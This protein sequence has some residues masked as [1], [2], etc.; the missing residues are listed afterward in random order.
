M[1]SRK[2]SRPRPRRRRCSRA[3]RAPTAIAQASAATEPRADQSAE[4]AAASR[5]LPPPAPPACNADTS[6]ATASDR[7]LDQ[8][9]RST[10]AQAKRKICPDS[11]RSARK[12]RKR[13]DG[14]SRT[15]TAFEPTLPFAQVSK[16]RRRKPFFRPIATCRPSTR[17]NRL[18]IYLTR[19]GGFGRPRELRL[20]VGGATRPHQTLLVRPPST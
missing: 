19:I 15:P 2:S 20:P 12:V 3:D 14:P 1:P 18:G 7:E 17:S 8:R 13:A 4:I 16:K 11:S 9:R 10:A 5:R 6:A